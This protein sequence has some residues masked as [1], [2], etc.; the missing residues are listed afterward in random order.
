MFKFMAGGIIVLTVMCSFR[1]YRDS[2]VSASSHHRPSD[3]KA[4]TPAATVYYTELPDQLAS[5]DISPKSKKAKKKIKLDE[6][7]AAALT[8]TPQSVYS[9][10]IA[11]YLNRDMETVSTRPVSSGRGSAL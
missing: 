10:N 7:A 4:L 6:K 2:L 5:Q 3:H 11:H 1:R 8:S 9:T